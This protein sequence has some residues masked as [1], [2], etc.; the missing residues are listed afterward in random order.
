MS[1]SKFLPLSYNLT[2]K[3]LRGTGLL[4]ALLEV[5]E[6]GQDTEK[7]VAARGCC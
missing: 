2:N 7:I 4:S 1:G 3:K 6:E 5:G